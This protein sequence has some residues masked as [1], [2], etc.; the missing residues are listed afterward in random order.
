MQTLQP[1]H[2]TSAEGG[3]WKMWPP[4][5]SFSPDVL[6]LRDPKDVEASPRDGRTPAEPLRVHSLAFGDGTRGHGNFPRWDCVNGWTTK[7]LPVDM[8]AETDHKSLP[9]ST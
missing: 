5:V 3:H 9:A 7:E 4:W 6:A 1:M 8:P 2:Y